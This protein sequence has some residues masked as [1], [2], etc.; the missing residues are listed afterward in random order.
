ML[1]REVRHGWG[2]RRQIVCLCMACCLWVIGDGIICGPLQ[3]VYAGAQVNSKYL[4]LFFNN[5]ED[6]KRFSRAI[7][8]SNDNSLGSI[9]SSSNSRDIENTLI[10]K[11]DA[12]FEKV[13]LIPDKRKPMIKVRV[14]VYSDRNQLA[15]AFK[16][17]YR[18]DGV[19]RSWY[20]Y[21]STLSTGM[22]WMSMRV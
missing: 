17:V 3:S 20:V 18:Q 1:S 6:I 4:R 9:F 8:Y 14:N 10:V 19:A 15:E 22:P 7:D 13:Q 11:L 2:I 12:L 21:E 5:P 16:Q